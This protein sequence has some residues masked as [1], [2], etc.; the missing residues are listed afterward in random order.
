MADFYGTLI[1]TSFRVK[2]ERKFLDDP[3]VQL[4]IRHVQSRGGFFEQ[5]NGYWAFGFDDQYPS[6]TWSTWD[7]EHEYNMVD[8]LM[9]HLRKG[10]LC[11]I[12]ISGNEKLRYNGGATVFFTKDHQTWVDMACDWSER[13]TLKKTIHTFTKLVSELRRMERES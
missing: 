13:A 3:N 10:Q 2:N 11:Q 7:D 9:P 8:I 5:E 6:T 4:L 12:S 1:S